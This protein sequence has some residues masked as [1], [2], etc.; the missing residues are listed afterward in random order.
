M[1]KGLFLLPCVVA[2]CMMFSGCSTENVEQDVIPLLA[3]QQNVSEQEIKV[4]VTELT[5]TET[6]RSGGTRVGY[7]YGYN[8][9]SN[10]YGYGFGIVHDNA[11]KIVTE[12]YV[13]L[14]DDN[15]VGYRFKVDEG[16]YPLFEKGQTIKLK[17]KSYDPPSLL[18]S[19]EFFWNDIALTLDSEATDTAEADTT[20]E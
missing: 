11:D 3:W 10:K 6:T 7:G 4:E 2:G 1:K 19:T 12:Y 5:T 17:I 8:F 18:H 9:S 16:A 15:G 14:T 20:E 13:T